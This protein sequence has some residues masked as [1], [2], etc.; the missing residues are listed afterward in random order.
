MRI[1]ADAIRER[2]AAPRHRGF[3]ALGGKAAP[4]G[5]SD[6]SGGVEGA[7]AGAPAG[8]DGAGSAPC[9]ADDGARIVSAKGDNPFCGDSL[10]VRLALRG[11]IVEKAAFEGYACTLCT[12]CSDALM[13][14]VTG[15]GAERAAGLSFED[16]CALWGGLEV[17]RTR[18]GCA[19]LPLTVLKRALGQ[20]EP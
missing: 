3:D 15:M 19:E 14:A 1:D 13:E 2:A 9:A 11:G 7:A 16:V 20:A 4:V 12:A 5:A 18:K 10:E 8:A 17:G 6:A